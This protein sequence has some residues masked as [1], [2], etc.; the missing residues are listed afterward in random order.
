VPSTFVAGTHCICFA[1]KAFGLVWLS[2][3]KSSELSS[4]LVFAKFQREVLTIK[5][6]TKVGRLVLYLFS[7]FN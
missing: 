6:E 3:H 7:V 4:F 1:E 2:L 5:L